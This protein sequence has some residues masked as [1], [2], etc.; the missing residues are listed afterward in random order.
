MWFFMTDILIR[1]PAGRYGAA[2]LCAQ[3]VR[4]ND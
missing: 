1:H 3:N 2:L 4:G